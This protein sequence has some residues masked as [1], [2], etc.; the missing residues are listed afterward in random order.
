MPL[1]A[2]A[3]A[4]LASA[5]VSANPYI[6]DARSAGGCGCGY[7]HV[8]ETRGCAEVYRVCNIQVRSVIRPRSG[9]REVKRTDD[10]SIDRYVARAIGITPIG[11]SEEVC[12]HARV[13]IHLKIDKAACD[14]A[15]QTHITGP[16]KTLETIIN[17]GPAAHRGVFSFVGD[18]SR[19]DIDDVIRV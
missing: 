16:A 4:K 7:P 19:R 6:V 1:T 2:T 3:I 12:H 10:S 17:P 13:L 8:A 5:L 9:R 14:T 11:V 18:G 15:S